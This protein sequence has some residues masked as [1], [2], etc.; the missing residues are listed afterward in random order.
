[1]IVTVRGIRK[2]WILRTAVSIMAL[3][4]RGRE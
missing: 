4:K 3:V 2:E 1:M